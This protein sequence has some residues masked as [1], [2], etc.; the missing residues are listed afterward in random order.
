MQQVSFVE[1]LTSVGVCIR[2]VRRIGHVGDDC[3]VS[4]SGVLAH[5]G[6]RLRHLDGHLLLSSTYPLV[7]AAH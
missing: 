3:V 1:L 2:C 4:Q 6:G 5:V 7:N